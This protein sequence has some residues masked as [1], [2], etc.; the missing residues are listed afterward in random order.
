MTPPVLEYP[1]TQGCAVIGGE[2]YRGCQAL[3][4]RGTYFYADFCSEKVFSFRLVDGVATELTDRTAE[5]DPPGANSLAR[6]VGFGSDAR[7]EVYICKLNGG[8]VLKI[9]PT[10]ITAPDWNDDGKA[11]FFDVSGFLNAFAAQ[12]PEADLTGNG[13]I[14]VFD[15]FA[16]LEAFQIGCG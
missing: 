3:D 9:V 6:V 10:G 14:D 15:V 5:L 2:V 11:D 12:L 7:G 16:F 13:T 8:Q 4:L 1:H